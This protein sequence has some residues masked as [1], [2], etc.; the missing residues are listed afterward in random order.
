M[1]SLG[2]GA[3]MAKFDLESAYCIVPVHP[4]DW[5]LLGMEWKGK[6]Y[7]D[8]TL[9]FYLGYIQPQRFSAQ[10]LMVCNTCLRKRG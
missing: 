3:E 8:K 9:P 2:V 1:D 5:G 10:W 6:W 4:D 7:V